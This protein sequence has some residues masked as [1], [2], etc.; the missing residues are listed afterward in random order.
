[1]VES[2]EEER[3]SSSNVDYPE[4]DPLDLIDEDKRPFARRRICQTWCGGFRTVYDDIDEIRLHPGLL[5]VQLLIMLIP[6]LATYLITVMISDCQ[7]ASLVAAIA[8]FIVVGMLQTISYMM[9]A[10][11]NAK[12]S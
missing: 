12:K 9:Q 10:K 3:K 7:T 4:R 11:D 6:P 2:R 1:M 5:I 8:A